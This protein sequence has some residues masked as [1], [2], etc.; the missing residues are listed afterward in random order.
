MREGTIGRCVH[1][2]VQG[3]GNHAWTERLETEVVGIAGWTTS[4][5]YGSPAQVR[6]RHRKT[7]Q[8]QT[9]TV[10]VVRQWNHGD[11]GPGGKT[12]FRTN[13]AID[14]PLQPFPASDDHRRIE[15]CGIKG[16]KQ[17]W[18]PKPPPPKTEAGV[19]VPVCFTLVVCALA[20]AYRWQTERAAIGEE[21]V[22]WQRW[23]R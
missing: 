3:Q 12:V 1:P 9:I 2:V 5:Q 10:V 20:T 6:Y 14:K 4:D 18:N 22:G 13:E 21:S 23:R 8:G 16:R 7:C 11:S 15:H 19:Q 17:A